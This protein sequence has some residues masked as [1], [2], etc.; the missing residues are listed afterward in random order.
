M[1]REVHV[2]FCEGLG[3]R[4]PRATHPYIATRPG[5]LYLAVV[6]DVFSRRVVGWA[7]AS[8]LR[9]ELVL[10][11]LDM[12]LAQRRPREVI[13]HSDQG[14]QYTSIAFGAVLSTNGGAPLDGLGGRLL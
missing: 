8:H 3:V 10:A 1:S 9:T 4:V 14:T 12:A 2:R 13:H 11:A 5:F 7:M 6:L